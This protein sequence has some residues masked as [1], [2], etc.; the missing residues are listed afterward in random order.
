MPTPAESLDEDSRELAVISAIEKTI[1]QLVR[2]GF[3]QDQA[4]AIAHEMARKATGREL[5]SRGPRSAR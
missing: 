1:S 4:V 5:R 3:E 2:E